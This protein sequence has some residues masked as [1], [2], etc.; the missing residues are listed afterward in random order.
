MRKPGEDRAEDARRLAAAGAGA[1]VWL[2][3]PNE[4]VAALVW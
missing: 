1:L 4:G 2:E 3:L